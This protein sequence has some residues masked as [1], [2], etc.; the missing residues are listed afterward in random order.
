[1]YGSEECA[2]DGETHGTQV[3]QRKQDQVLCACLSVGVASKVLLRGC[4]RR[5]LVNC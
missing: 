1:M 5:M 2:K 3:A 4:L